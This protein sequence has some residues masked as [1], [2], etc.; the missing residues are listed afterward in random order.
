MSAPRI[1]TPEYYAHMRSLEGGSWWNAGMRD[2]AL[3]LLGLAHLPAEGLALDV[4]C[5]SGQ[6]MAWLRTVLPGWNVS[7]NYT[8]THNRQQTLLF[9][10]PLEVANVPKH[11][12]GL[13]NSYEFLKGPLKGLVLG[14]TVVR[15]IDVPLVDAAQVGHM[16][17]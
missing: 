4:G 5:G 12:V 15:K 17:P 1:F 6:T 3:G 11:D 9:P 14:A 16:V 7:L 2:V 10:Q 13:L 8:F